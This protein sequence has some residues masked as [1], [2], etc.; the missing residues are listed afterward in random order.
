MLKYA[1]Q[2]QVG[3][4]F[5]FKYSEFTNN[6]TIK[7]N[8]GWVRV[9]VVEHKGIYD[10]DGWETVHL[11]LLTEHGDCINSHMPRQHVLD[12]ESEGDIQCMAR[13]GNIEYSHLAM[14]V[15]AEEEW[16]QSLERYL[17]NG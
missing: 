9:L 16:R 11:V 12:I 2:V 15:N 6:R 1:E 8:G 5:L 7:D 17:R 3:D 10:K 14:A 4:R 13:A